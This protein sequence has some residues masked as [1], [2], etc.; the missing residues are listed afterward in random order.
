M[1][2]PL[3]T[4]LVLFAP[5]FVFGADRKDELFTAWEKAQGRTES[6]M[7]DRNP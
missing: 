6:L 7:P 2:I 5:G 3:G 4:L 1:R